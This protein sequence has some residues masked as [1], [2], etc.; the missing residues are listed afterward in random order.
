MIED[1]YALGSSLK[2]YKNNIQES[3]LRSLK[4]YLD[5]SMLAN[6]S[7]MHQSTGSGYNTL[8]ATSNLH[9]QL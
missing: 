3:S 7:M 4:H 6:P 1:I 5:H 9:G 2:I 8:K